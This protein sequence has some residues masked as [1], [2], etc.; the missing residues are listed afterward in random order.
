L[1]PRTLG[2]PRD[3]TFVSRFAKT[4]AAQSELSH[5][6][7]LPAAFKTAADNPAFELW[8]SFCFGDKCFGSHVFN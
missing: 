2:Y 3:Q 1:L 6:A 8:R 5:K 7:M 4:D